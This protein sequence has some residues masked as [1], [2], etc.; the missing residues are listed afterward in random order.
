MTQ[1]SALAGCDQ[2]APS[3]QVRHHVAPD[4]RRRRLTVLKLDRV[5]LARL[6]LGHL[7]TFDFAVLELRVR[8]GAIFYRLLFGPRR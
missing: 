7:P 2:P 3:F 6:D 8:F 1:Q 5:A 4:A